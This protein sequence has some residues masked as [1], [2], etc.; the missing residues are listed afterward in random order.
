MTITAEARTGGSASPARAATDLQ[1][2]PNKPIKAWAAL[3]VAFLVVEVIAM[4]GWFTSGQMRR[5]PAGP[6][7]IPSWMTVTAHGWEVLG[8]FAYAWFLW[9]FLIRPWKQEGR[10]GLDG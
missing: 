9:V 4:G 2:R 3:G 1:P 7:P 8:L 6:T 5:T 10:I